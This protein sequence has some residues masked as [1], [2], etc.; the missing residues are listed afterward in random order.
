MLLVLACFH[1]F[2]GRYTFGGEGTRF[3]KVGEDHGVF[4]FFFLLSITIYNVG[5]YA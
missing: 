5:R 4:F 2:I 1:I 3:I